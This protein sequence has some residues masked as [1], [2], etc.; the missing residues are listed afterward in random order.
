MTLGIL[1]TGK[2]PSSLI[3]RFGG[4]ADMFKD[5]L[6]ADRDYAMFD[7]ETG[8][9]PGAADACDAYLVT[10]SPAGVYDDLPWIAPLEAFLRGAKG[11]AKLVGVCFGH[12]IMAQA[13]GGRAEKSAKGW[14]LGLQSYDVWETADWMTDAAPFAVTVAHQD[15]VTQVPPG[16]RALAGNAF[17]ENGLLSY[18]DQPAISMQCH[19][20]FSV[21]FARALFDERSE[22]LAL[23]HQALDAIDSLNAPSDRERVGRWI[24]RFLLEPL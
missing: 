13:F 4:Y 23:G 20:E 22:R 9:L 17:T 14:G 12:Q 24:D 21:E 1:Q 18:T 5:L 7:V 15:Q 16:A 6:G 19:P 8:Q 11:R 3:P 2:P 10:G